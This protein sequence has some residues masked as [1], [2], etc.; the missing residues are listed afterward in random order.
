M[1]PQLLLSG[2]DAEVAVLATA[3][4]GNTGSPLVVSISADGMACAWAQ[5]G[6]SCLLRQRLPLTPTRGWVLLPDG[7][8]LCFSCRSPDHARPRQQ[9]A[10]PAATSPGAGGARSRAQQ[11][12]LLAVLEPLSLSLKGVLAPVGVQQLGLV[13]PGRAHARRLWVCAFASPCPAFSVSP[14]PA[15]QLAAGNPPAAADDCAA[16]AAAP[17]PPAGHD[18]EPAPGHLA[19]KI[20][21]LPSRTVALGVRQ[22]DSQTRQLSPISHLARPA[23]GVARCRS[24]PCGVGAPLP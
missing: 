12:R 5:A 14:R 9:P 1:V 4:P 13:A 8:H 11:S 16:A 20:L 2:H 3:F 21:A 6:A 23:R 15:N 10:V 19:L 7:H 17:W 22:V 24:W 18:P